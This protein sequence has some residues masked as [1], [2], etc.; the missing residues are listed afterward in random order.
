MFTEAKTHSEKIMEDFSRRLLQ[1]EQQVMYIKNQTMSNVSQ[2]PSLTPPYYNPSVNYYGNSWQALNRHPWG[3]QFFGGTPF[4]AGQA[5]YPP[6]AT[7]NT[8]T[9]PVTPKSHEVNGGLDY[10]LNA[11][12]TC[13]VVQIDKEFGQNK[14]IRV[15]SSKDNREFFY[16][17]PDEEVI[18]FLDHSFKVVWDLAEQ[19]DILEEGQR[20]YQIKL[21]PQDS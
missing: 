12:Q 16:H 2:F 1:L 11:N 7:P 9:P 4:G 3:P 20:V 8:Q 19:G 5:P 6:T 14:G 21:Y 10:R 15:V 17:Y 13:I 18:Q